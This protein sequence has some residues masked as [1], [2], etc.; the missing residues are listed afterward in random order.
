MTSCDDFIQFDQSEDWEQVIGTTFTAVPTG[1]DSYIPIGQVDLGV[2]LVE[3][4]VVIV[5]QPVNAKITWRYGG[6]VRQV[7]DFT[8]GGEIGSQF[9]GAQSKPT[10]MFINKPEVIDLSR[11]GTGTFRLRYDPPTWFKQVI[12]IGW[13]YVGTVENFTKDTLFEIGNK[14][15][16]GTLNEENSLAN[17]LALQQT[18]IL[19]I[20]ERLEVIEELLTNPNA[21]TS[22]IESQINSIN[23]NVTDNVSQLNQKIDNLASNLG[24]VLSG[25]SDPNILGQSTNQINVED[26]LI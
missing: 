12:V 21:D 6:E 16:I 23:Q 19:N 24:N 7:W 5:V 22:Q 9:A 8:K 26:E 13:V 18:S 17:L 14:I 4:Y 25:E 3:P 20:V 2:A 1:E 10:Q 11:N 15:G